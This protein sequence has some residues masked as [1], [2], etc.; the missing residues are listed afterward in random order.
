MR[1]RPPGES[2]TRVKVGLVISAGTQPR[3]AAA[4]FARLGVPPPV[5]PH[6]RVMLRTILPAA[7]RLNGRVQIELLV[8]ERSAERAGDVEGI[9]RLA[10]G[11]ESAA[12]A[13]DFARERDGEKH[14][15]GRAAGFA[16]HDGDTEFLRGFAEAGVE[17]L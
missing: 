9:A 14:R 1:R 4:T 2:W 6:T 12:R 11:T 7:G 16:T 15:A 3:P 5:P 17:L 13:L 8:R 10:A